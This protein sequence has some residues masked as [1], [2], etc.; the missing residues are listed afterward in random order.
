VSSSKAVNLRDQ[1]LLPAI[2]LLVLF[3]LLS[4]YVTAQPDTG[5]RQVQTPSGIHVQLKG[6]QKP[7]TVGD[8]IRLELDI[9]TP[10]GYQADL[11]QIEKQIGDFTILE[12]SPEPQVSEAKLPGALQHRRAIL[13]V[14]AY[15]TGTLTFP[16]LQIPIRTPEGNKAAASSSPVEIQIQSVLSAK[17]RDLK[18]LKK[19]VEM[20][21]PF[22]WG[23]WLIILLTVGVLGISIWYFLKRRK[24][25][26]AALPK[27]PLRD[28][29]EVAEEELKALREGGLPEGSMVKNFYVRLSEIVRRIIEAA[30]AVSAVEQTTLEIMESLERSSRGTADYRDRLASLLD[31]CDFVKFAKYLPTKPELETALQD[32]LQFLE[33]SRR[34]AA[35]GQAKIAGEPG[36][37]DRPLPTAP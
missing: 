25:T 4:S 26:K 27:L 28:P 24:I 20:R 15:K 16:P 12:F 10:A 23:I 32:A 33:D 36:S 35:Q 9:S 17:D 3:A 2:P 34:M 8:P 29:F 22:R 6:P 13:M 14:A 21:E 37:V 19:Q 7:A 18:D 5:P 31:R 30:C 1:S 11:P